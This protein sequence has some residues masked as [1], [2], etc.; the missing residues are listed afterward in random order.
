METFI[1]GL[2]T[3]LANLQEAKEAPNLVK[4]LLILHSPNKMPP[5]IQRNFPKE[6]AEEEKVCQRLHREFAAEPGMELA[7]C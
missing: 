6:G 5:W 7:A 1:V 3:E 4:Q 2:R